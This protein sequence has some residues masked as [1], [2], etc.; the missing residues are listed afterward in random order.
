MERAAKRDIDGLVW[1][2]EN[3]ETLSFGDAR[4]DAY[5]IA[6]GIRNVTAYRPG[7]GR[8]APRAEARRPLLLPRILDDALAG[9][10]RRLRRLFAPLV[11]KLGK[12]L[13]N[14][15]DSYRYLVESIR[16]FPDMARFKAHDRARPA[17]C[18]SRPSRSSAGWSRSTAAGRS[19]PRRMT[20][21]VTHRLAAPEMGPHARAA[22][23]AARDRARSA[24]AAAGPPAGP[25]SPASAR[26]C[27]RSRAMPMRSR[28]SARPRSSSARRSPPAPIWSARRPR[29]ICSACRMRCRRCRS[30]RSALPS[31]TALGKPLE[32]LFASFDEEPVGAASIA[33]VHRAVTTEGRAVAVKVLRPGVEE[34]F[35]RAHRHL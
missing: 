11:P 21:T 10:R 34:D 9:L 35:A 17:S 22:R 3:A 31:S 15:E 6:F 4:F 5:T 20:A 33:Q 8:G 16:R 18:A 32:A 25:A 26:A 24:D 29:A 27:R 12:L 14:D 19:D 30:P 7:A 23:R 13:A 2:E 28:R 1:A